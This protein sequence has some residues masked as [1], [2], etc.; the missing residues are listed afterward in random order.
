[1]SQA[2]TTEHKIRM[3]AYGMWLG[4]GCPHGRDLEHWLA[5]ERTL[6]SMNPLTVAAEAQNAPSEL[7]KSRDSE[8]ATAS[9]QQNATERAAAVGGTKAAATLVSL[10]R[11]R[12][13]LGQD[14]KLSPQA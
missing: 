14:K 1:M 12:G 4:E 6:R 11:K 3:L 8:I 2:D 13:S 7:V 5:A 10:K 9:R